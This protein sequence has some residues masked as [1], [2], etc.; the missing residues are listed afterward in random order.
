MTKIRLNKA[1]YGPDR[2]QCQRLIYIHPTYRHVLG[3]RGPY[4]HIRY[5]DDY[6]TLTTLSHIGA[7][8]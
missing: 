6:N 3:S 8:R 5:N 2:H 4:V 1:I 7:T